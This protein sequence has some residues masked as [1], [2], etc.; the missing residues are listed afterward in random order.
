M[1]ELSSFPGQLWPLIKIHLWGSISKHP[2]SGKDTVEE[3]EEEIY[4]PCH[5]EHL[6]SLLNIAIPT[7]SSSLLAKSFNPWQSS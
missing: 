6:E 4:M 3:T 2:E 7:R 1:A 5:N